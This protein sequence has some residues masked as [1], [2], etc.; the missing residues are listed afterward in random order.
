[1]E[2]LTTCRE[3]SL[4]I[5]GGIWQNNCFTKSQTAAASNTPTSVHGERRRGYSGQLF[6]FIEVVV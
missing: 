5:I 1:M 6:N 4:A 3:L 2:N